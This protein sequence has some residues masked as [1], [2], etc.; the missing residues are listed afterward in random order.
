[1]KRTAVAVCAL[2]LASLQNHSGGPETQTGAAPSNLTINFAKY[3]Q[4]PT[5]PFYQN[6][7]VLRSD[8]SFV[9]RYNMGGC[10]GC[11]GLTQVIAGS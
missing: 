8:G 2:V 1:M 3:L 4:P 11:H 6:A 7:Y 9:A 10:T 5:L